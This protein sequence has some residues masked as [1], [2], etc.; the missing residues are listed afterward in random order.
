ME[1]FT[2]TSAKYLYCLK[3]SQGHSIVDDINLKLEMSKLRLI[4]IT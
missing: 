2:H 4:E 3:P 1:I